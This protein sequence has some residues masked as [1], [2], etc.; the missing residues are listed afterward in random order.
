[1]GYRRFVGVAI[2]KGKDG[3]PDRF[4][5]TLTIG[6]ERIHVGTFDTPER[7]SEARSRVLESRGGPDPESNGKKMKYLYTSI[8]YIR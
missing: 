7:A 3:H 2:R 6:K 1:M 8:K 5:A 4:R